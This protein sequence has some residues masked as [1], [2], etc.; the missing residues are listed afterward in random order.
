M[1][2]ARIFSA[3][4]GVLGAAVMVF[5]VILCLCSLDAEPKLKELPE[6]A[7]ACAQEL[8]Q[9]VAKADFEAISR[10]L[11]GH[12]NLGAEEKMTDTAGK[13]LWEAFEDSLSLTYEGSCYATNSGIGCNAVVT[14]LDVASVAQSLS[15]H[16]H[17]LMTQR[18]AQAEEMEELYDENNNFRTDLVEEVLQQAMGKALEN[19]ETVKR[20]VTL[21]LVCENGQW[22]AVADEAFLQA[23]SGGLK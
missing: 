19:G 1:K 17:A 14:S 7:V 4:V 16:A 8:Q 12:P 2:I 10:C 22:Y 20:N 15:G 6:G 21:T 13:T 23:I 9:A 3:V 11:Y 18:V 5:S